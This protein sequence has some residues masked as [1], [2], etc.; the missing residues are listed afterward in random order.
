MTW[1]IGAV[2]ITRVE[3]RLV[4]VPR[5]QI[6]PDITDEQIAGLQPWIEPYFDGDGNVMLSFHAL[7]VESRGTTIVV[8]TCMGT[9]EP[10]P[11][12]GDPDLPE[13]LAAAVGGDLGNVDVVLCTHLHWDHVGWNT[14]LVDGEWVPTFPN[15][16]YLFGARELEFFEDGDDVHDIGD[17]SVAPILAAGLVELIDT[18][19][20]ITSEVRTVPTPGHTPGHVSVLIESGGASAMITGDAFHTPLQFVH[21]EIAPTPFDWDTAMSGDT[22]RRLIDRYRDSE[23]L[24]V[25]THFAPPTA[26]HVRSGEPDTWFDA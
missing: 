13:R 7:V 6:L 10:R 8:D 16:R 17:A 12:R 22:R 19:H 14:R 21:P 26:G 24:I 23:T 9:M 18:Y 1:T 3:D 20:E 11:V 2:I 4:H 15:A 5:E 25:G